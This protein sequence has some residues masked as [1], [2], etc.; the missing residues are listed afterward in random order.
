MAYP[1]TSVHSAIGVTATAN[2]RNSSE[3][4]ISVKLPACPL[5]FAGKGEVA[6]PKNLIADAI[7]IPLNEAFTTT[8]YP[9]P[10][11]SIFNLRVNTKEEETIHVYRYFAVFR[12]FLE[13]KP[14]YLIMVVIVWVKTNPSLVN[15][16]AISTVGPCQQEQALHLPQPISNVYDSILLSEMMYDR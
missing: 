15:K 13:K 16:S 4:L 1:S 9:N 14:S 2:C 6:R 5:S 3:R 8:L 10:S 7:P 12:R 11:H